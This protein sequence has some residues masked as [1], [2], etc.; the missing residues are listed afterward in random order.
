MGDVNKL[1]EEE[2]RL[3]SLGDLLEHIGYSRDIW[4]D[5]AEEAFELMHK[6]ANSLRTMDGQAE[7]I[8]LRTFNDM[9]ESMAIITYVK[10]SLLHLYLSEA[11]TPLSAP[12]QCLGA[13]ARR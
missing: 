12:S 11:L 6:L 1:G 9:N 13:D 5:F 8:L 4:I 7:S 3:N 2:S 10:V